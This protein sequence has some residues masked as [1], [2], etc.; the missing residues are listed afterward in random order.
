MKRTA[1]ILLAAGLAVAGLTAC[2][3]GGSGGSSS[4]KASLT[5]T[6]CGGSTDL[7]VYKKRLALAKKA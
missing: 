3:S 6:I 1:A 7:A 4:D 5:M 2:S